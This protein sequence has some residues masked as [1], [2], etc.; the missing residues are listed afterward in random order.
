[1]APFEASNQLEQDIASRGANGTGKACPWAGHGGL[2]SAQGLGKQKRE[3]VGSC[4][5]GRGEGMDVRSDF[6]TC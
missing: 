2:V 1:M 3:I 4:G 5:E 6:G